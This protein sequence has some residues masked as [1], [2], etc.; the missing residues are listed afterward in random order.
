VRV[1]GASGASLHGRVTAARAQPVGDAVVALRAGPTAQ[2]VMTLS[3]RDGAYSFGD[4]QPGVDYEL[5]ADH[6]GLA[7]RVRTLRVSNADEIVTIDLNLLAPIQ[8][9]DITAKA[10]LDFTLRNGA[11]GRFYQPEIMTGGVAAL[12]YNNDGCMDIFFVNGAALPS[13]VKTG[14]EYHNRLYRN[15]CDSTFTDV[16]ETAGLSGA[17]Y[18]IGVA[19]GHFDNYGF[20]DLFVAGVHRNTLYRNRR[21]G[22]FEEVTVKAGLGGTVPKYGKMW[23]VSAGWF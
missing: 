22:T 7:S 23:A 10:G 12:D 17:G 6:E 9:Q 21:D 16:T 3:G 15:N 13:L 19:A 8:F 5:Q 20:C 4:L 18:A 1:Y 2:P 11:T 14:P